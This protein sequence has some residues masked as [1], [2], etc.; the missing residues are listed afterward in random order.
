MFRFALGFV[1]V[2]WFGYLGTTA[3][4]VPSPAVL[5]DFQAAQFSHSLAIDHPLFPLV[6]GTIRTYDGSV[7][8]SATGETEQKLVVVRVLN[9][10]RLVAGINA[11]VVRDTVWVDG[12]LKEDTFDWYAQ[13]NIGNVWYLGEY[14]TDYEYDS[15]DNLLGTSHPGSWETGVDGAKPGFVMVATQQ[16]SFH[17]FQEFYAGKAEDS[18]LIVGISESHSVPAGT[19]DHVLQTRDFSLSLES[20]GEKFYAPGVGAI[21]ERDIDTATGNVLGTIKLRSIEVVPEPSTALCLFAALLVIVPV[22]RH[23]QYLV[24]R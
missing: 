14:V 17:Y 15:E 2:I 12:L 21:M 6:P 16:P 7:T 9:E 8:D 1:A 20:Y 4:A 23:L 13:D 18:A 5:P 11:R 10:T 24:P 19:Y 3:L 22:Q